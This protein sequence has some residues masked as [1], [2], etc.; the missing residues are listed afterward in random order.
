MKILEI[1]SWPAEL[2]GGVQIA[3]YIA[4]ISG[5]YVDE[6]QIEEYVGR[7]SI[8]TLRN[9][10]VSWLK[11]GSENANIRNARHE[12]KYAQMAPETVPPLVAWS[13]GKII[14]GNHRYRIAIAAS[15]PEIPC[16]VIP[17]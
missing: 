17:I 8:A 10:P 4:S 11:P 13:N 5:S 9:V 14:D 15:R 7:Q 6:E 3:E 2:R 1:A 16:Y 12:R